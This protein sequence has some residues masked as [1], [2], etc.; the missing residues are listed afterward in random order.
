MNRNRALFAALVLV[1]L[2]VPAFA[3]QT[4][5]SRLTLERIFS[6]NEFAGQ[7]FGPA[8]WIENG[9]GYTTLEPSNA[10][11]GARDIVR[12]DAASG[13][14]SVLVAADKLIPR[15]QSK[16]LTIE[17]YIWSP[18]GKRLMIF[19]GS[20]RVWRQ[21]TRGD[22]WVLDLASSTLSK[23]GGNEAKPSTLMFAKFSPDGTR[24][25]YVRENNLYVETL[26]DNRVTQLTKDGSRTIINGTFDWVYEE[27]LDLRDGW[28]WSPDG[29]S[30]AFWQLDASGVKDFTLIN[31]TAGIYPEI[32]PI[33]YPK[34][35]ETISSEFAA[36]FMRAG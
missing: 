14:R 35:G 6:S 15:G 36:Q 7:P 23:L 30:I 27:E 9:S 17:D 16:P 21:N 12:Y 34:A 8:R 18:D 32:I 5:S 22:F 24:V 28:R 26:A 13:T 25:G 10:R 31:Y 29:R 19:T 4:A 11:Q 33:Q 2:T 3:Q 1:L 20:E